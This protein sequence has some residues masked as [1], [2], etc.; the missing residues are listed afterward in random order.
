[1]YATHILAIQCLQ[2]LQCP[3]LLYM[4]Q[5]SSSLNLWGHS[6]TGSPLTHTPRSTHSSTCPLPVTTCSF[7]E[8]Y[9]E[10]DVARIYM[11]LEVQLRYIHVTTPPFLLKLTR[12]DSFNYSTLQFTSICDLESIILQKFIRHSLKQQ[13]HRL[14]NWPVLPLQVLKF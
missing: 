4:H 11:W 13:R 3:P 14:N 5:F 10:K 9:F 8:S 2:G 6:D 12:Q 1:M 7:H